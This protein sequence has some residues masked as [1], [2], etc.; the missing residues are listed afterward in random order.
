MIFKEQN[1]HPDLVQNCTTAS[2]L[3]SLEAQLIELNEVTGN[4][5]HIE[6]NHETDKLKEK[7]LNANDVQAMGQNLSLR[8]PR[9]SLTWV[10]REQQQQNNEINAVSSQERK[11]SIGN[12]KRLFNENYIHNENSNSNST[13]KSGKDNIDPVTHSNGY[14]SIEIFSKR[15]NKFNLPELR[16]TYSEPTLNTSVDI[17]RRR[18]RHRKRKD[19]SR[20]QKFGYEITNVDDFLSKVRIC[21][22][23]ITN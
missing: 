1:E 11:R 7:H 8:R 6:I 9:I 22:L 14:S 5:S 10:L 18:H 13:A 20:S 17:A 23:L 15:T 12:S 3:Q 21:D 4:V 19:R 16:T 2:N